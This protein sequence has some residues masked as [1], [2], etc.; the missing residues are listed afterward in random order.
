MSEIASC[1][2]VPSYQDP[3]CQDPGG[4][5]RRP[6]H[7]VPRLVDLYLR[8]APA[9]F[10]LGL[11]GILIAVSSPLG[12]AVYLVVRT[13]LVLYAAA[14]VGQ[15]LMRLVQDREWRSDHAGRALFHGF[16]AVIYA[17]IGAALLPRAMAV[18]VLFGL[19]S[20]I[21]FTLGLHTLWSSSRRVEGFRIP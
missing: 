10:G 2:G 17:V 1:L 3:S 20:L 16:L 11:L 18:A 14:W 12:Q 21:A 13:T 5:G 15:G 4:S 6:N 8:I 19:L 9:A 7:E